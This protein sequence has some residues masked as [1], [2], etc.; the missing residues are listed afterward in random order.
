MLPWRCVWSSWEAE[1]WYLSWLWRPGQS[2]QGLAQ[3]ICLCQELPITALI[4]TVYFRVCAIFTV[5]ELPVAVL[6]LWRLRLCV[7]VVPNHTRLNDGEEAGHIQFNLV[8]SIA[9]NV[10]EGAAHRYNASF[11]RQHARR[12]VRRC[13]STPLR[14]LQPFAETLIASDH[15]MPSCCVQV[16]AIRS[17][18]T[19][20]RCA[21]TPFQQQRLA[22]RAWCGVGLANCGF[23]F[24]IL[25]S[26]IWM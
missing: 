12:Q 8:A 17:L 25:A 14:R 18:A 23:S 15:S 16:C 3:H 13:N 22:Q 21:T 26:Y 20:A 10:C 11:L 1:H 19:D 9:A 24:E 7:R 2:C 4:H 5:K 6:R